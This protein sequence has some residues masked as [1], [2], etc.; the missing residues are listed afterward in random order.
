[1]GGFWGVVWFCVGI[2]LCQ[3]GEPLVRRL[4]GLEEEVLELSQ[5]GHVRLHE[6]PALVHRPPGLQPP[7][8]EAESSDQP[9]WFSGKS[10][11]LEVLSNGHHVCSIENHCHHRTSLSQGAKKSFNCRPNIHL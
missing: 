11:V 3:S 8:L 4:E 9:G 5:L 7:Q 2:L 10:R 1:M 6:G